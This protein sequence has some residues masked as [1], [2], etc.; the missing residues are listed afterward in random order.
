[1]VK[2]FF[3]PTLLVEGESF[4][5]FIW[6]PQQLE[7]ECENVEF[8]NN[9][10]LQLDCIRWG[11][12]INCVGIV[13]TVLDLIC[14]RCLE[15]FDFALENKIEFA[16]RLAAGAPLSV[17]LWESDIVNID[18]GSGKIDISPRIRDAVILGIP[19]HPLCKQDCKGLCPVCGANL[20]FIDC[21]HNVSQV[22]ESDPRWEKLRDLLRNKQ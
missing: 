6:K 5:E 9:V 13:S 11:L 19:Q 2:K 18:T 3:E 1:M 16:V 10:E 8:T 4:Q 12:E 17:K 20:N 15:H 7:L 14:V 22:N 21:G